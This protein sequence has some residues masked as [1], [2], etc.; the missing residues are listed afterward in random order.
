MKAVHSAHIRTQPF[1]NIT[2]REEPLATNTKWSK[3]MHSSTHLVLRSVR[4][5]RALRDL[6]GATNCG[7]HF[8]TLT[9]TRQLALSRALRS[10]PVLI[11][12]HHGRP[13]GAPRN[14]GT[15]HRAG[16]NGES[17]SRTLTKQTSV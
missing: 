4:A 8:H 11:L 12:P 16:M 2:L 1:F 13:L 17:F 10:S 5:L 15:R 3:P 14:D 6:H 7:P 9:A